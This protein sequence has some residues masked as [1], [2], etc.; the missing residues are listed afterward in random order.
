MRKIV[1]ILTLVAASACAQ[2]FTVNDIAFGGSQ[3]AAAPA[4]P[5]PLLS[6]FNTASTNDAITTNVS[7]VIVPSFG[8]SSNV[9]YMFAVLQQSFAAPVQACASIT[10]GLGCSATIVGTATNFNVMA[11][12][13][14]QISVWSFMT[15][16]DVSASQ[17]TVSF[18]T[19]MNRVAIGGF[20]FSNTAC[21][22]N[23]DN[24]LA[25]LRQQTNYARDG[26]AAPMFSQLPLATDASGL[27][28][29][30]MVL[31]SLSATCTSN[32]NSGLV[33]IYQLGISG[34]GGLYVGICT[35]YPNTNT[36]LQVTNAGSRFATKGLEIAWRSNSIPGF[37][38][39]PADTT[40]AAPTAATFT[41]YVLGGFPLTYQW[42][43]NN[44][45]GSWT[46]IPSA[47]AVSY[48]LTP[49]E[50]ADTLA[51]FRL[52]STNIFGSSTSTVATLTVTL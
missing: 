28:A 30:M 34:G 51:Q 20:A 33:K 17:W 6:Y 14:H 38:G 41:T 15:N 45:L 7:H 4:V 1:A 16:V 40:V 32:A 46:N 18:A 8:V 12:A 22:P 11:S 9:L 13:N 52:V 37:R 25:A 5:E 31:G 39:Q 10:N 29:T 2:P 47:T 27:N 48:T 35:N 3:A 23:G 36:L 21:G 19:N 49:T 50:L 26:G 44:L 43:R 24:G 42:S